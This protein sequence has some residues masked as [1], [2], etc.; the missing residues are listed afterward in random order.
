MWKKIKLKKI[1]NFQKMIG[2]SS[3]VRTGRTREGVWILMTEE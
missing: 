3:G 2:R 1:Q